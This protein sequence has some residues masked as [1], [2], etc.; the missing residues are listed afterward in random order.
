MPI[1]VGDKFKPGQV[2][3]VSGFY[4]CDATCN[5]EWSTDV[6]GH[7]FPPLPTGCRGA[8]WVLKRRRP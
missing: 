8:H 4:E 6:S 2:V 1:T 7:R 3:P 5:H